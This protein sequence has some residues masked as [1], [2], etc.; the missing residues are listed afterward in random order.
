[1]LFTEA[2]YKI[3][4]ITVIIDKVLQFYYDT[5]HAES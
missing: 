4:A 1:M 2:F 3:Y 5:E